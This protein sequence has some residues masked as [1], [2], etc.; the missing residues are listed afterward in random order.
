MELLRWTDLEEEHEGDPLVVGM[1][2]ALLVRLR[3]EDSRVGHVQP[4]PAVVAGEG[5]SVSD[6]AEGVDHVAWDPSVRDARDWI[7][8][9]KYSQV[10]S[11]TSPW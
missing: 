2:S 4:D 8:C 6:P 7:T 9:N 10:N 11:Y 5:E 1:V 3:I